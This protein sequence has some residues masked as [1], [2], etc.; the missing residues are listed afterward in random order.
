M[1]QSH[2]AVCANLNSV[3][4]TE[5]KF[6]G[7]VVFTTNFGKMLSDEIG[8]IEASFAN[9]TVDSGEGNDDSLVG[10]VR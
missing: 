1:G 8:V 10:G 5:K 3:F 7:L 6:A 2:G 9:V 4:G